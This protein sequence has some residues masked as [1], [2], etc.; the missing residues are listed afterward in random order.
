M[1]ATPVKWLVAG[2]SHFLLC[3]LYIQCAGQSPPEFEFSGATGAFA[4]AESVL[5]DKLKL[6]GLDETHPSFASK[7]P[8]AQGEKD[9]R[10]EVGER[11]IQTVLHEE[12]NP[13]RLSEMRKR[14]LELVQRPSQRDSDPAVAFTPNDMDN[15]R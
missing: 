7:A 4:D 5:R 11:L 3:I 13:A 9:R 6:Y 1:R 15:I 8:A 2:P 12:E 14:I 10:F